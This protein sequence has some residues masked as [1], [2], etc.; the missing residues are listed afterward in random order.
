MKTKSSNPAPRF[1]YEGLDRVIHERARLSVLTSL[2]TRPKGLSF[3]ELKQLCGLTDGNLAR[4]LQV[5]EEDGMVRVTK[6]DDGG[7]GQTIV[8][9][10]A[11]GRKRYLE[12][13]TTLEQVV[14]DAAS[15]LREDEED[16]VHR[17]LSHVNA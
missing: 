7:R 12:Y 17:K 14:R 6:E 13:L 11:S 15:A 2:I 16:P 8:R 3:V 1:A 9:V 4:H 5:L 10:T